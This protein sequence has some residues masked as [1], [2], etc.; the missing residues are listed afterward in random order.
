MCVCVCVCVRG[1]VVQMHAWPWNM[2]RVG[3]K[4][5]RIHALIAAVTS[6]N[7]VAKHLN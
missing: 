6:G 5:L 2:I 4:F 7:A 3:G 1:P